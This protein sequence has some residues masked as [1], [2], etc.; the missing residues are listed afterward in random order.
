MK[1]FSKGFLCFFKQ[2][3]ISKMQLFTGYEKSYLML[4]FIYQG[5]G[6]KVIQPPGQRIIQIK[7]IHGIVSD[8]SA[9]LVCFRVYSNTGLTRGHCED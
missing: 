7:S 3:A 4:Y 5:I 2:N 6:F 9:I 1:R 8:R